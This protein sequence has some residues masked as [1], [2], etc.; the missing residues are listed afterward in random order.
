[1]DNPRSVRP[2]VDRVR[3]ING[4]SN[5]V[6]PSPPPPPITTPTPP[7]PSLIVD[8][9]GH[10]AL[11]FEVGGACEEVPKELRTRTYEARIGYYKSV[12]SADWFLAELSGATV[13]SYQ[14][15]VIE[16]AGY[17]VSWTSATTS[18]STSRQRARISRLLAPV[19]PPCT[20][21][22]T[23]NDFGFVSWLFQILRR[24][25]TKGSVLGRCDRAQHVQID[26]SRWTL[27][28]R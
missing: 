3:R 18:S 10:Y 20:T 1:M 9:T 4:S 17:S 5:P 27:T 2:R 12:G 6:S 8:L 7:P 23:N 19:W 13:H 25:R 24:G 21:V 28:R 22:R 26:N 16:V 11:T 15:V 14:P